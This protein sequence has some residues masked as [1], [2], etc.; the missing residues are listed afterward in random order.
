MKAFE[1]IYWHDGQILEFNVITPTKRKGSKII[2]S[3]E[4]Y[5]D[6]QAAF[7]E[8]Y[9]ILFDDVIR[10]TA[11]VDNL[12]LK[13][14]F[15]AGNISSAVGYESDTTIYRFYLIEGY[16][17]IESKKVKIKKQKSGN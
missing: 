12:S 16:I 9:D 13:D 17:E 10:F 2:L 14:N 4:L 15:A 8:S 6:D 7:R 11:S 5:A 1:K 3:L